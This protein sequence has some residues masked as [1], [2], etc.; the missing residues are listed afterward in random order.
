MLGLC[1]AVCFLVKAAYY[2]LM[3]TPEPVLKL[4][5][6]L[7]RIYGARLKRLVIYGSYARGT[8][9]ADSDIDVAV[10]L[11]GEVRPGRE[12]DRMIDTITD[13]N[14]EFAT[15]I[16]VFPVSEADFSERQSP[17]LNNLRREGIAA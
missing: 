7:E 8:E 3:K 9:T 12:I 11:D 2:R 5:S 4:R 15:L 1:V 14:L 13:L 16:S 17:L 10:V 6:E